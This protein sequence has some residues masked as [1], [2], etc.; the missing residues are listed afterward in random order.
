MHERHGSKPEG[1]HNPDLVRQAGEVSAAWSRSRNWPAMGTLP[2]LA[3]PEIRRIYTPESIDAIEVRIWTDDVG[4]GV[5]Q[6][7]GGVHCIAATGSVS[8]DQRECGR[9]HLFVERVQA[10]SLHPRLRQMHR[11]DAISY[12]SC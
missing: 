8:L 6:C 11:L 7:C 3:S 5:H 10:A 9:Q 1:V 4:D 12:R 2:T